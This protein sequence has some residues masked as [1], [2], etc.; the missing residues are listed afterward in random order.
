MNVKVETDKVKEQRL[1]N[2]YRETFRKEGDIVVLFDILNECGFFSMHVNG[3]AD[4]VKQNV[5]R[6]ILWRIGAWQE[7]NG[8]DVVRALMNLPSERN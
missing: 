7:F 1:R 8:P 6:Y 3:E 2:L 5:A 4:L